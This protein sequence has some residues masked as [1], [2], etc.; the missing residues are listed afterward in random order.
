MG[1]NISRAALPGLSVDYLGEELAIGSS[2]LMDLSSCADEESEIAL[3]AYTARVRAGLLEGLQDRRLDETGM[4]NR[5]LGFWPA[6]TDMAA[7]V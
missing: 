7:A 1:W 5:E 4:A 6:V 2:F 3:T